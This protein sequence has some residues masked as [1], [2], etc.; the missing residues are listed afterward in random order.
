MTEPTPLRESQAPEPSLQ[1]AAALL[2]ALEEA[3]QPSTRALEAGWGRVLARAERP[4]VSWGL[5]RAGA[6]AATAGAALVLTV[7]A[8]RPP[9]PPPSVAA[10]EQAQR[11]LTTDALRPPLPKPLVAEAAALWLREPTG[12]L[13]LT[14][15]AARGTPSARPLTLRTPQGTLSWAQGTFRVAVESARTLL[16]VEEGEVRWRDPNGEQL[17]RA[18]ESLEVPPARLE[19][20]AALKAT[21]QGRADGACASRE[22][23]QRIACLREAAGGADLA[24]QNALFELA[25]AAPPEAAVEAFRT[26]LRRFPS[27]ALMPEARVQVLVALAQAGRR[28]EARQEAQAFLAQLPDDALAPAVA[29]FGRALEED[30]AGR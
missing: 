15:G 1:Q 21:A 11:V 16:V 23:P 20:P 6:L 4:S 30:S 13:V 24:A 14:R 12:A 3:P 26:Y 7:D 19:V 2:R 18:G 17:L 9:P 28:Q 10:A 29:A 22:G 27:G 25:L 5:L 8:L